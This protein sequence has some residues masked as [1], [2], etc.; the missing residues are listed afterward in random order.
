MKRSESLLRPIF[1]DFTTIGLVLVLGKSGIRLVN[2][3]LASVLSQD[4]FLSSLA[5]IFHHDLVWMMLRVGTLTTAFS[6]GSRSRGPRTTLSH[7]EPDEPC[8]C[9]LRIHPRYQGRK[10]PLMQQPGHSVYSGRQ[11]SSSVGH[12]MTLNLNLNQNNCTH[13]QALGMRAASLHLL[14]FIPKSTHSSGTGK[15]WSDR[16]T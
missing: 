4:F 11:S 1:Y 12:I 7:F 14:L 15:I 6:M 16:I 8:C 10:H 9:H 2:K 3:R 13:P 5:L